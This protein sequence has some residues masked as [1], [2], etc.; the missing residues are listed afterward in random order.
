MDP[1][2]TSGTPAEGPFEVLLVGTFAGGGVHRYVERQREELPAAYDVAL[3]DMFSPR[4]RGGPLWLAGVLLRTALAAL[5]FVRRSPPDVVHVHTSHRFSFYRAAFYV[6]FARYVWDRPTVLHVH[7][8]SFDA[9]V[10]DP[11]APVR[12]LQRAVFDASDEVVV[13]SGYWHDVIVDAGLVPED[14]VSVVPNAVDPDLYA[15]EYGADPP[16]VVFV[17]NLI[18]RKGV[19]ALAEAVPDLIDRVDGDVAVDVAGDGPLRGAVERL[20]DEH[21]AVTYHGYVSEERKRALLNRATV[22]TLPTHAEG[23]PIAVLEAMAGG[24]AV[25][26][27]A[28]GSIP[29]VI[30]E[31]RGRLVPPEDAGALADALVDLVSDPERAEAMGRRN[32]EAVLESYSWDGAVDRILDVYERSTSPAGRSRPAVAADGR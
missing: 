6:L 30:D 20:A 10:A 2:A 11:P 14:A 4:D 22:Y 16:R 13:L 17:S 9:F 26:S 5:S 8:S 27:T 18:E 1:T 25:V 7:G 19:R 24:N 3:H 23:L 12:A 31:D 28:V 21:D 15:P 32:R 29:E